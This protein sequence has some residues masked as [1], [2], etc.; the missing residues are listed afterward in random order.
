MTKQ[1]VSSRAKEHLYCTQ[2][3]IFFRTRVVKHWNVL[4]REMVESLSLEVIK[5]CVD[6]VL[7]DII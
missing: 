1:M 6:M 7:R 3:R 5:R 2:G 4:P